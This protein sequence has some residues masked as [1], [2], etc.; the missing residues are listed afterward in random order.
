MREGQEKERK[1][2]TVIQGVKIPEV[3]QEVPLNGVLDYRSVLG[4]TTPSTGVSDLIPGERNLPL[5]AEPDVDEAMRQ[6][7]AVLDQVVD[8]PIRM[9]LREIGRVHLLSARDERILAR[10]ME[11]AKHIRA[12]QSELHESYGRPPTAAEV[13]KGFLERL[14]SYSVTLDAYAAELGLS[15]PITLGQLISH[16]KLRAALDGEIDQGL[17]ARI[18][19]KEGRALFDTE[20]ALRV[21]SVDSR[22]VS[23][24]LLDVLGEDTYVAEL[25]WVLS[26][27]N[28]MTKFQSWEPW[29]RADLKVIEAEGVRSK[30]K[31][32]EANLRLVVSIAKKY[33]GRGLSLLDLIQEGNIGLIKAT[34]KFDYRRGYKFSTYATWWI[35]QAIT[36]GIT[37]QGRTIRVPVHMVERI[38][39]LWRTRRRL[40]QEYGREPTIEEIS[41][42][43]EM[44]AE[45][46]AELMKIPQQPLSLEMPVGEEDDS[47]LGDFIEDRRALAPVDAAVHELLK[48]Q[49]NEVLDTL[50][51]RERR[52]LQLRFGLEDGRVRTLE[53][54]GKEYGVTRERIRQIEAK[55]IRKLRHSSRSRKLRDFLE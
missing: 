38:S 25:Q 16:R 41:T 19:E 46:I 48:D 14:C 1:I 50:N 42:G 23:P 40:V 43:M 13:I 39:N 2:E 26:N 52:V 21:L 7:A 49:V 27:T 5:V 35:W 31:L 20:M 12:L 4:D 28:I 9:Y 11:G 32:T 24:E 29:L 6:K 47:H 36:R 18:A 44:P 37:D 17:A 34:E 30:R 55:A 10:R 45:K 51:G 8:D 3:G 33:I 53:Q 54:V 15:P 22:L